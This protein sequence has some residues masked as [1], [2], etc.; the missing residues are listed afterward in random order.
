MLG[1]YIH[2]LLDLGVKECSVARITI[3]EK[4]INQMLFFTFSIPINGPSIQLKKFN[5]AINADVLLTIICNQNVVN[6]QETFQQRKH[7]R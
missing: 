7:L 1:L 3:H 5:L 6:S 2:I 4:C